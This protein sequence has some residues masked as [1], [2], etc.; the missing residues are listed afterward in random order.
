MTQLAA[1]CNDDLELD[2][3]DRFVKSPTR[4]IAEPQ[5]IVSELGKFTIS[6]AD[7]RNL[8]T[9][10]Q[11]TVF[12]QAL[13]GIHEMHIM[14]IIHGD[15]SMGNTLV[16]TLEPLTAGIFDFG[17]A[18]IAKT[19]TNTAIGPKP[20]LA[21]EVME[22]AALDHPRKHYDA[23]I[24][25]WAWAVAV[26][27]SSGFPGTRDWINS[28]D[29]Q[30]L[31]TFLDRLQQLRP[32][33]MHLVRLLR[34]V[35]VWNPTNRPSA[36]KALRYPVWDDCSDRVDEK[37]PSQSGNKVARTIHATDVAVAKAEK[38][39]RDNQ[40]KVLESGKLPQVDEAGSSAGSTE[41]MASDEW[42]NELARRT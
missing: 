2:K 29:F 31:H 15:I 27:Y 8:S 5:F 11:L 39:K 28:K 41:V 3:C 24:D 22:V 10:R 17:K 34:D 32:E 42:R 14:G 1:L 4:P 36:E 25:V 33:Y 23:L 9:P 35:L 18:V 38:E 37:N 7:F 21:P 40:G 20:T 12:R 13:E 19:G 26:C 6:S 30:F 16:Q